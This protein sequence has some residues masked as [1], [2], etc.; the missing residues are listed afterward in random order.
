[1]VDASGRGS[2]T[3]RW[4]AGLGRAAPQE[5]RLTTWYL[6]RLAARAAI[7]PVAGAAFRDVFCLTAPPT[8]PADLPA[9]GLSAPPPRAPGPPAV[10]EEV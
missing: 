2:R 1:M 3:P 6:D 10:V 5:E 8:R 7:D 9:H 4:F